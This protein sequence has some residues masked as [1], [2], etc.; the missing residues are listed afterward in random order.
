MHEYLFYALGYNPVLL[1]LFCG[2]DGSSIGPWELIHLD[3]VPLTHSPHCDIVRT[4]ALITLLDLTAEKIDFLDFVLLC[5]CALQNP[6]RCQGPREL[7]S[8]GSPCWWRGHS[9]LGFYGQPSTEEPRLSGE[10][11]DSG[12]GWETWMVSL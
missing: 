10:G 6:L 7:R 11:A 8:S 1:Y 9:D 3:P 12:T 4:Y 5:L 2:S